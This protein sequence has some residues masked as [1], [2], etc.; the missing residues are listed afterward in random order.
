MS[1]GS[2]TFQ[3]LTK[4]YGATDALVDFDLEIGA[5]EFVTF[6]GPSGS[7]KTTALNILA[8][9][10]H[11]T[12]G[13]VLVSG[14]SVLSLPPERRNVG[15]VF[16]SYSLFPHLS[17]F[18]NIA[19]PLKLRKVPKAEITSKVERYLDMI[20]LADYGGRMPKELSGGQRQRVAFA[21]AVVFEPPVLLMDEPL[22]ALDLKLR[23]TMQLE[24]KQYHQQI[25]CTVIFVTHDQGEALALSDRIAVM[26]KGQIVQ[27]DTPDRIYDRPNSRY[28]AEFIGRTNILH[29][30]RDASGA[31]EITELG[32][33][34]QPGSYPDAGTISIRP[35]KVRRSSEANLPNIRFKATVIET[36]FLGDIVQYSVSTENGS[37]LVFEEH[38]SNNNPITN[39]GSVVTVGFDLEDALPLID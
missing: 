29:L 23:Q 2:V 31:V 7:G 37:R 1:G 11:A 39:R 32:L 13:E 26:G 21:R 33:K 22:G 35:E 9:F 24:I 8:G 12:S 18:D 17:V 10:T 30:V 27:V 28:V 34:L 19:F 5:G 16:Q 6:L 38:R 15:M 36:L 3:N 20:Q 14:K 25:G 4:R